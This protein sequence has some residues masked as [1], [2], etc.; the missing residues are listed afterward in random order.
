[1]NSW[2]DSC[3]SRLVAIE[4]NMFS[5]GS[6]LSR[7]CILRSVSIAKFI[8]HY[9]L[10]PGIIMKSKLSK[11]LA[12]IV[13]ALPLVIGLSGCVIAIGGDDEHGNWGSSNWQERQEDNRHEIDKLDIGMAYINIRQTMGDPDFKEAFDNKGDKMVVLFYRTDSVK[14]DGVTSKDECTPLVFKN[15]QLAGWGKKAYER[16]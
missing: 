11:Q 4:T 1:M 7:H 12:R 16:I 6:G 5:I 13:I 8:N 15:D 2:V 3:C 14:S 9:N 10:S